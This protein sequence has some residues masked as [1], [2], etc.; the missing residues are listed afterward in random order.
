MSQ[1]LHP[2]SPATTTHRH[3]AD[4]P[5]ASPRTS[6]RI[7][8]G[9]AG[10]RRRLRRQI[11]LSLAI[12]VAALTV[13]IIAETAPPA[14]DPVPQP[15][16]APVGAPW[17][18]PDLDW[19]RDSVAAYTRRLAGPDASL[20]SRSI[21]YPLTRASSAQLR[22]L[23]E[24]V[25]RTGSV[26]AVNL[27]PSVPLA[28]LSPAD[29]TRFAQRIAELH[30][31]FGSYILVRFGAEMNG[32]WTSWG[33]QPRAYI[34]AFRAIADAVHRSTAWADMVWAPVYG[35]G[36]PYGAAYGDVN[37]TT[38]DDRREMD[39]NGDGVV[40]ETDDPYGPY[41]PGQDAVD[42]VGL[43]FFHF[44]DDRDRVENTLQ[45]DE[46]AR[47]TDGDRGTQDGG[48]ATDRVPSPIA[49]QQRWDEQFGYTYPPMAQDSFYARFAEG[50]DKPLWLTTAALVRPA[51]DN[52][53]P[54]LE[55]KQTWWREVFDSLA[56]H[57]RVAAVTWLEQ[58]RPEAEADG[59]V[60]DWRVTHDNTI[61][62]DFATD[63]EAAP[64]TL[65]ATTEV[66]DPAAANAATVQIRED[67]SGGEMGWIVGCAVALAVGYLLAGL[68]TRFVPSWRYPD[69]D[70]GGTRD[71]R[72]DLMRGFIIL[73]VVFTHIELFSPYSFVSLR[74][75]GAITGAEL[76]VALS[77]V[78]LGMVYEPSVRALGEWA[79]ATAMW[80]RAR[81]QY[82]TA[83]A[84]ILLVYL[85]GRLPFVDASAI[86]TFTDRGTG[87]NGEAASGQV[88]NLYPNVDRLLDYPPPNYALRQFFT[89]QMGPWVFN[90]MG[91]FVVLS[92][93]LPLMMWLVRRGR[94]WVL[95]ALSWAAYV[96]DAIWHPQLISSQFDAVFPL[97]TWQIVFT[98]GLVV[99]HYRRRIIAALSRG[100]G[101]RLITLFVV[102]YAGTLAWL[103]AGQRFGFATGLPAGAYSW[104]Y[105]HWYVRVFLQ[106]GRLLDLVLVIVTSYA[107]LTAFWKP[108]NRAIGWLW[109]PLGQA[110]LYVFIVHVFLTL[111]VANIPGLDRTSLVQGTV[112]HTV[113]LALT[114]LM[115]RQKFLFSVIPR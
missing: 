79:T 48:F 43:T 13:V 37:A 14:T 93:L 63:L 92:V 47:G 74:A 6:T 110:S 101:L 16:T 99:G 57:P 64:L 26:P 18:G 17:F 78:V 36:Y 69:D 28:D 100:A 44:G 30:Q 50:Y 20:Y 42:W 59:A 111:A 90:I 23:V 12:L 60:V 80:R 81:R 34:A 25:S 3:R 85:A 46:S 52:R 7:R 2:G 39:T 27:E 66:F 84:V 38:P 89:L 115:V 104:L 1:P 9:M 82:V 75:V 96:A 4:R 53:T 54:E 65:G 107:I 72:V 86:T 49:V 102:G 24:Q 70:R 61:A 109:I 112:L 97:L 62:R 76:F 51:D 41:W 22:D 68:A 94:W 56:K 55:I 106:P 95:L 8:G 29:A 67:D 91:L 40:D 58:R 10:S 5:A 105:D 83:L 11:A 73:A 19:S 114:Y 88:Y 71:L 113:I 35:A 31:E 98:H 103:W 87:T 15:P 21:A 77:G 45:V 33:Q 108:I 32:S